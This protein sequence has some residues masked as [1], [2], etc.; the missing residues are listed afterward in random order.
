[1]VSVWVSRLDYWHAHSVVDFPP[2]LHT[3]SG[4]KV[5]ANRNSA[6]IP[7]HKTAGIRTALLARL[8]FSPED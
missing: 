6:F 2:V 1:M 5:S 4:I 3:N 8:L 7:T